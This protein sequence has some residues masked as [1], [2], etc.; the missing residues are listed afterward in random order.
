[1]DSELLTVCGRVDPLGLAAVQ[2]LLN[3][4]IIASAWYAESTASTN[5]IALDELSS[6]AAS[7]LSFPRLLLADQ[8]TSGR[9][10]RGR[11]W[12]SS[13]ETLTFSIL[14]SLD[15]DPPLGDRL[16]LAV[17]VG[18]AQSL[19]FDLAPLRTRLKWPNDVYAGG[20]KVAGILLETT[21]A[22][23][24]PRRDWRWVECRC[25]S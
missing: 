15:A 5:S 24:R 23:R 7:S 2:R 10:R 21:G 1:M 25:T 19:E 3:D 20:G 22:A 17:G 6:G 18:I 14:L 13:N 9:G 11:A 12:L 4:Q 16:S 8:Q